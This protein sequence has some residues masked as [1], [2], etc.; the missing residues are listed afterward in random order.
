MPRILCG[1]CLE[2]QSAIA[3]RIKC[4]P[5]ACCLANDLAA[6]RIPSVRHVI[7]V[8]FAF[9]SAIMQLSI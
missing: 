5:E 4:Q 8:A 1:C 6:L 9:N 3:G 7:L 2:L